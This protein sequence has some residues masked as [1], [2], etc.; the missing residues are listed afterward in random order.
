MFERS[1]KELVSTISLCISTA[2]HF[3]NA[4]SR[5]IFL[6]FLKYVSALLNGRP[7]H[8]PWAVGA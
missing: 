5:R 4:N 7:F 1:K 3:Q 2:P 6:N 8:W